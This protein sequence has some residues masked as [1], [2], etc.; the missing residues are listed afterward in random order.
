ML[1]SASNR[2]N[3]FILNIDYLGYLATDIFL[4]YF[5]MT[6]NLSKSK[7][8]HFGGATNIA[9][10]CR[11]KYVGNRCCTRQGT[12]IIKKYRVIIDLDFIIYYMA[13]LAK[14]C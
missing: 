3:H 12:V 2:F 9:H 13:S 10:E 1:Q 8:I 7:M 14:L 11:V 4:F 5:T 6:N